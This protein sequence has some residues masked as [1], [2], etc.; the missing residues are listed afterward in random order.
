MIIVKG[1]N[2]SSEERLLNE[3]RCY[4]ETHWSKFEA[5][6]MGMEVGGCGCSCSWEVHDWGSELAVEMIP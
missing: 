1:G 2:I 3:C 6:D 5:Q 4:C